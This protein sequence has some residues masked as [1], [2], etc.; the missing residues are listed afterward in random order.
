VLVLAM[1][2]VVQKRSLAIHKRGCPRRGHTGCAGGVH[3]ESMQAQL[4]SVLRSLRGV[5][6]EARLLNQTE[7]TN[8]RE[9]MQAQLFNFCLAITA[10]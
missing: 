4:L 3:D 5:S 8:R 9:S 7:Q 2:S 1:V 10:W 6:A